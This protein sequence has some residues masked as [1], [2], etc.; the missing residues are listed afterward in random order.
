ME[1]KIKT[2][3]SSVVGLFSKKIEIAVVKNIA[4]EA[5]WKNSKTNSFSTNLISD[6]RINKKFKIESLYRSLLF[7][8]NNS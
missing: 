5:P 4:I 8:N 1:A 6:F 2:F 3:G 7:L